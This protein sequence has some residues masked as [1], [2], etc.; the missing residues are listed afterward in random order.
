[1]WSVVSFNSIIPWAQ[2][3]IM[4]T[5]SSDLPLHIIK[6][7]YVVFSITLRFLVTNTLTSSPV[8]NKRCRLPATTVINLPIRSSAAVCK[9]LRGRTIH[10]VWGSQL[11]ADN[12]DLGLPHRHSM[13]PLG[14]SYRN[15]AITFDMVKL[16]CCGYLTV[17]NFKDMFIRFDRIHDH[18]RHRMTAYAVLMPS[19]VLQKPD[20]IILP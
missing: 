4:F 8:K 2:P 12:R 3:F 7:C 19:I 6:R 9:A 1:V 11:F 5:S 15:I 10:S 17:K 20:S 16:K 14:G 13:P 18:D